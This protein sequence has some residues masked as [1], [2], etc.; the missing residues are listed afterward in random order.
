VNSVA[1]SPDGK[2]ALSGSWDNT[3]R[4]WDVAS[5][6]SIRTFIGHISSVKSVAFS[7]DGKTVLSGSDDNDLRLWDVAS[8]QTIR[9]YSAHTSSVNSVAFSPDGKTAFS[10]SDDHTLRLWRTY[11]ALDMIAW[12]RANRYAL[13]LSCQQHQQYAIPPVPAACPTDAAVTATPT[14]P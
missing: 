12:V 9:T 7:P 14:I 6:Q 11:P 4:L 8:S 13:P 3:L 1:F 2:T 10:S 5:G